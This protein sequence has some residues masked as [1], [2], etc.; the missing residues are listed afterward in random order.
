MKPRS[1]TETFASST[2]R[3]FPFR[4]TIKTSLEPEPQCIPG[5]APDARLGDRIESDQRVLAKRLAVE[6]YPQR[7]DALPLSDR[8][9]QRLLG[10][11]LRLEFVG[12]APPYRAHPTP[13]Q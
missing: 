1:R 3:N 5:A 6:R 10:S 4:K 2:G 9:D 7:G 12:L 11:Q 8:R 13:P